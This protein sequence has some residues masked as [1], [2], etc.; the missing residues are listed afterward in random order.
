MNRS[1]MAR[2]LSSPQS[3]NAP[4]VLR[5]AVDV[6]VRSTFDYLPPPGVAREMLLPGLRV[7]VP[8]GRRQRVGFIVAQATESAVSEARLKAAHSILDS[9]PIWSTNLL[10]L[11]EWAASYYH[12][13]LGEVIAAALPS[14]WKHHHQT[15]AKQEFLYAINE[16][17]RMALNQIEGKAPAQARLLRYLSA[18]VTAVSG[19]MLEGSIPNWRPHLRHL[20]QRKWIDAL[21]QCDD[22]S[23]SPACIK[24]P[25]PPLN[26]AQNEAARQISLSLGRFAS[27]LLDGVT[28]SGKTE[29]YMHVIASVI[30]RGE[31]AL[32]LVPEISLT[33]QTVN[34]F[35]DRFGI[36]VEVLHSGLSDSD[37][38]RAF[39]RARNGKASVIIGTRS[40]VW[41]PLHRPGV[42]VLD[43]EHD[44]SYKQQDGFRYSARDVAVMRARLEATPVVLGSATPSLESLANV[45]AGRYH[46][47]HLTIRA[48]D[49][50]M[51]RISVFDIRGCALQAGISDGLFKAI[52]TNVAADKQSLIFINRRGYAP[53]LLCHQCGSVCQCRRCD[54]RMTVHDGSSQVH[55]HHCGAQRRMPT[56]CDACGGTEL[57]AL[58]QGTER[59]AEVL[60]KR[61]GEELVVR[62]DRDTTRRRGALD[63]ALDK[64]LNKRAKVLVGTQMLAKGHHFPEVT[65][66]AVV[67]ADGQLFSADLRA[68]ERLAQLLV[69]VGGRAGRGS[70][71]GFFV[72]QTHH[73]LHPLFQLLQDGGYP[74]IS[75]TMLSERK[76]ASL[77]PYAFLA[78]VR[79]EASALEPPL[80]FLNAIATRARRSI[81]RTSSS[82]AVEVMGPLPAPMVRRAGR[83]RAQLLLQST[84][85][86]PLHELLNEIGSEAEALKE[87]KMVRWSIDVD[88][89]ELY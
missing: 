26:T 73:P 47:L 56:R 63:A 77:P 16:A 37:R 55:C 51:P 29:V 52:D 13:P 76:A 88:P 17:G 84:R 30:E 61:Y 86:A 12:H 7:L 46:H 15:R 81:A 69:Q 78:M 87:S 75:K 58:G 39:E 72:V 48:G 44:L 62:I 83:H 1:S 89:V 67:D 41:T 60:A 64:V 8:F 43:E 21:V 14:A 54:A 4:F 40:A 71:P 23:S 25:P 65:L 36:G 42:I 10:A 49:S 2:H 59:V 18:Q 79:A 3:R 6:P 31:Q 34:R 27:F 32:M 24:T 22:S 35:R 74:A 57:I 5:V 68:T 20:L 82:P 45:E 53:T 9:E 11:I 80:Q 85:R 66:V 38:M 28:G 50:A 70:D 33:S 19:T